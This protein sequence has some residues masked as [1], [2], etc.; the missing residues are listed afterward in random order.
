MVRV[1]DGGKHDDLLTSDEVITRLLADAALR[2]LALTCVLPAVK[3]GDEW[4]YRRHDLEE[5]IRKQ[6]RAV[7]HDDGMHAK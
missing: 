4:C 5:W 7:A 6:P 2:R 1:S 3:H